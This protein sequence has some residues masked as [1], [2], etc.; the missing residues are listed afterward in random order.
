[1]PNMFN[2]T[3]TFTTNKDFLVTSIRCNVYPQDKFYLSCTGST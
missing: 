2:L 1:M 3:V